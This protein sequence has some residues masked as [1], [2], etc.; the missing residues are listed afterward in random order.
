[1]KRIL[2]ALLTIVAVTVIAGCGDNPDGKLLGEDMAKVNTTPTETISAPVQK[3]RIMT[4]VV[5]APTPVAGGFQVEITGV[6]AS[7][8]DVTFVIPAPASGTMTF[9]PQYVT[10][11]A[12]T[13]AFKTTIVYSGIPAGNYPIKAMSN[14]SGI[15]QTTYYV[16]SFIVVP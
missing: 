4:L 6:A 15:P 11:D 1:M 14:G 16:D 7:A 2:T 3:D 5:S 10:P 13:G 12:I 8:Y 9:P